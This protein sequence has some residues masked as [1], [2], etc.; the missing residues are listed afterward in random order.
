MGVRWCVRCQEWTDHSDGEC[1][2][3][4]KIK[5]EGV[6]KAC[7]NCQRT[8]SSRHFMYDQHSGDRLR[9]HC[10]TCE[11]YRDGMPTI[12]QVVEYEAQMRSIFDE[13]IEEVTDVEKHR[14]AFESLVHTK[15]DD[16]GLLTVWK[17]PIWI[18]KTSISIKRAK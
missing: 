1:G 5:L 3:Q 2:K 18:H 11:A 9:S 10:R 8:L 15:M 14:T 16:E 13:A 4:T 7:A 6:E 12:E 17:P